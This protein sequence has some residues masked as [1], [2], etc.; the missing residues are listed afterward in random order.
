MS[1]VWASTVD[2]YALLLIQG[3]KPGSERP[4][5]S[6]T[7]F[8]ELIDG[9][10]KMF[11]YGRYDLRNVRSIYGYDEQLMVECWEKLSQIPTGGSSFTARSMVLQPEPVD[12][13]VVVSFVEKFLFRTDYLY[14]KPETE[15]S[16]YRDALV[17]Q[18][19]FNGNLINY[20]SKVKGI[21]TSIRASMEL[22]GSPEDPKK[23]ASFWLANRFSDRLMLQNTKQ[24]LQGLESELRAARLGFQ[25][26][27]SSSFE[28][29]GQ[30]FG[31]FTECTCQHNAKLVCSNESET[32]LMSAVK[33]L[34]EWDAFP[35]LENAWDLVPFSFV[36]DWFANFGTIL[37]NI[38]TMVYNQYL[39]VEYLLR[40]EKYRAKLNPEWVSKA[41]RTSLT[42]DI[43]YTL[44]RRYP[45]R[46][47]DLGVLDDW[48]PSIPSPTNVVD[49]T[50][51][52]VQ[53]F[54]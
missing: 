26:S 27:R 33:K 48:E 54:G 36:V 11:R 52:A 47:P 40:S 15:R 43:N 16:L 12:R 23:W 41:L 45:S 37:D 20:A 34:Y 10:N 24:I 9:R 35:T 49:L 22:L 25:I 44:Y 29:V 14:P 50:A 39:R 7:L 19:S 4:L 17:G 13:E 1:K 42:G 32:R 8:W 31:L 6:K 2:N 5:T 46:P 3:Y 51:L 53:L 21:G 38:D 28:D 30:T 18:K